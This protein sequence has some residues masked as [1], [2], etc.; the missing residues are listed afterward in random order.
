[1]CFLHSKKNNVALLCNVIQQLQ[2][3]T[4]L[5]NT[6]QTYFIKNDNHNKIFLINQMKLSYFLNETTLCCSAELTLCQLERPHTAWLELWNLES[7]NLTSELEPG[8]AE[9]SFHRCG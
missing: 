7:W 6:R 8:F 1:M 3:D 2:L 4:D 9:D 5:F